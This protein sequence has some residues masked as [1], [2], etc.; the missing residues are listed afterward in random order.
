M[1]VLLLVTEGSYKGAYSI[2][3]VGI[4]KRKQGVGFAQSGQVEFP[5]P[6]FCPPT[7]HLTVLISIP[8]N[9]LSQLKAHL[10][11]AAACTVEA[12]WATIATLFS[13]NFFAHSGYAV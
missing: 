12:L 9:R 1:S 10:R 2:M 11:K 8:S 4:I 7:C 3:P 6:V 13:L 5:L